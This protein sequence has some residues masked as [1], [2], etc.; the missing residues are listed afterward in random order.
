MGDGNLGVCLSGGG[1][2]ASLYG[3]GVLRYLAEAGVLARTDV[4]CSVSGGSIAT[5]ALGGAVAA[6][7]PEALGAGFTER[8]LAPFASTINDNDLR[9][10]GFARWGR[11]RLQARAKT[12]DQVVGDTLGAKLFPNLRGFADLPERP[13]LVITGTAL[14]AG[15]AFRFSRDFLGSYDFGYAPPPPGLRVAS[16][17]AASAAAPPFLPALQFDTRGVGLRDDTPPVVSISD[18]GVYDNLGVEWFQGW[19]PE[20]RPPQAVHAGFLVVVNASGPLLEENRRYSGG[21]ALRR[22]RKIQYAQTQATRIRWLVQEMLAERQQGAYVGITGDPRKFQGRDGGPVDPSLYAGALPSSLVLPLATLRT[23]LNR[24]SR[25]ETDLLAYHGYW[26]AHARIGSWNP[27]MAVADPSWREFEG[28]SDARAAEFAAR[29][30]GAR[31]R[32]GIGERLR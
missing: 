15:R 23:D 20:R 4:V 2:R 30:K 11:Q 13:Q 16:A 14:A 5:A 32:I 9:T 1:F 21:A 26:S 17:V 25:E 6:H 18:G 10:S 19:A 7:G 27:E 31:R 22:V 28:I 29:L 12:R 8:V 3:L 24:F